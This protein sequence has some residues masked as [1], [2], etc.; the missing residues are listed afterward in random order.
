MF[1]MGRAVVLVAGTLMLLSSLGSADEGSFEDRVDVA[2]A[3]IIV[4]V[5]DGDGRPVRGLA[6]EDFVVKEDGR[7][8]AITNFEAVDRGFSER[9]YPVPEEDTSLASGIQME[10]R[11]LEAP[12]GTE[13]E[14]L[15]LAIYLDD[16]HTRIENRNRIVGQL[17]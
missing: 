7:R 9:T 17:E 16:I 11:A 6:R 14:P 13:E 5:A 4:S 1:G 3:E 8:V 2:V 12:R 10:T 15:F